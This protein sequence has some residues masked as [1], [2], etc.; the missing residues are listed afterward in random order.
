MKFYF[1]VNR[2]KLSIHIAVLLYIVI[3]VIRKQKKNKKY[4]LFSVPLIY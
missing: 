4:F 3:Q 2:K 1:E